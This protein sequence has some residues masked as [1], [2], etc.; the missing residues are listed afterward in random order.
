MHSRPVKKK[1]K[2]EPSQPLSNGD[3]KLSDAMANSQQS[4]VSESALTSTEKRK[5]SDSRYIGV[6]FMFNILKMSFSMK[7]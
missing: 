7:K 5:G 3:A 4:S 1:R 2:A 6:F